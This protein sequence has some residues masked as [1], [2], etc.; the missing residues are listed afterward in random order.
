[1]LDFTRHILLTVLL[2]AS[3]AGAAQ[4]SL[5]YRGTVLG[6]VSTG[7]FAPYFIGSLNNGR[8]VRSSSAL[9]DL[10][11][12][13]DVDRS[14]RFRWGA[15]AEVLTGYSSKNTYGRYDAA[16]A[17]WGSQR[18]GPAAIWI[19]QL[20]GE[21]KFRGVYLTVGQKS[22]R[23]RI[24][25][26][27]LSSG[28]LTLSSNAR[29]IPGVQAGF[30]DFQ[31]IPL[32][33]GWLQ[34]DGVVQYGKYTDGRFR[35]HQ[36]NDYNWVLTTGEY[37][38]YRRCYFRTKPSQP[39]SATFG[40]QAAGQFGGTSR[41]YVKGDNWRTV[42]RGFRI[43]DAAKMFLPLLGNGDSYYEGS[44]LGS[45]D[46]MARY[47]LPDGS[48]IQA[49]FEWPWEDG[50]SIGHRNGW[51]GLWGIYYKSARRSVITGAA[52]EYLDFCNQSG[53]IHWAPHDWP[54]TSMTDECT[55]GDNYYNN[56]TYTAWANYGMAIATPF[57]VSPVYNLNGYPAFMNNCARGVHAAVNGCIG[58]HIDFSVKYSWQRGWGMGRMPSATS[59]D[60]HSV[61]AGVC[62]NAARLLPGLTVDLK[63]AADF[64]RLRGNN[65]GVL[66]AVTYSGSLKFRK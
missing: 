10:E 39:F 53:P 62:W 17:T 51:D 24:L 20:Y 31:D 14:R 6:N 19:Q 60:N 41:F 12:R 42:R 25:D 21:I 34:I 50:S 7:D 29:G 65:F 37:F 30:I 49:G 2:T 32:T 64:G 63:A 36:F 52:I 44:S 66:A 15:G 33:K 26:E 47:R 54:G 18:N 57:L 38:I 22:P 45:W 5:L 13:V 4:D 16:S 9:L 46:F 55:G 3:L 27:T 48:E 35:R 8:V 40:M 56:D 61:M 59:L 58:D 11:A 28:D 23:S 1:M 43:E